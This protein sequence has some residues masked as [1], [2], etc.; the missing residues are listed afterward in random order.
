MERLTVAQD[1]FYGIWHEAEQPRKPGLAVVVLGGSEGNE[2]IP[3]NVGRLFA[4]QGIPA[5]G[6]CYWN[7]EGL[8]E[9]CDRVPLEPF[10]KAAA[11]LQ[12]R[13]FEEIY[14]YGI[15]EGAKLALLCASLMPVFKGVIALSPIHCLWNGMSGHSGLFSKTFTDH[16]EFTYRGKEFPFMRT[17]V[18][19]A[20]GLL[21]LLTLQEINLAYL[22]ADPLKHFNEETAIKV[23]NIAGDILFIYA[24]DDQMWPAREAV[25]YMLK[26]LSDKHFE[27][28]AFALEYEKAS[29]ILVPLNPPQLKIFK[30]E[31]KYPEA[32]RR[33]R[34]EAFERAV[35]WLS[36]PSESRPDQIH[37]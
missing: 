11:W 31:R 36:A 20:K 6:M 19:K 28:K 14:L 22:Y 8:P 13:G 33:N 32:C 4:E 27:H 5:L 18:K 16:C 12:Q 17:R 34:E 35:E 29:H 2:N 26:R 7:G 24:R 15:S 30:I 25:A 10:E 37:A 9:N 21:H 1:G 3:L 23:E